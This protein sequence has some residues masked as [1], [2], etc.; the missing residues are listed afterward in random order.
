MLIAAPSVRLRPVTA[1]DLP[2]LFEQQCDPVAAR[3]AMVTPRTRVEFDALWARLLDSPPPRLV[4]RVIEA[5]DVLVGMVNCFQRP[6]LPEEGAA[7]DADGTV[8]GELDYV[9]YWLAREHWGRGIATRALAALLQEVKTRPLR[10][11][12]AV[13]NVASLRVLERCG[14]VISG[15]W[16]SSADARFSACREALLRLD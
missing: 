7:V 3:M 8:Q 15:Y 12:A 11:R 2:A 16:D 14:F 1:R 9:G 5:D 13:T 4:A 10:A 6:G